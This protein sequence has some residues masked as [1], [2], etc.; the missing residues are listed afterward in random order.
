MPPATTRTRRPNNRTGFVAGLPVTVCGLRHWRMS[1]QW[2]PWFTLLLRFVAQ[3]DAEGLVGCRDGQVV[4]L[5][6]AVEVEG[7]RD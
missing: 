1:R 2:H 6:G 3:G 7:V 5:G 4:G